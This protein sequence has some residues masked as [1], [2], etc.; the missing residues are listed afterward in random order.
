[1]VSERSEFHFMISTISPSAPEPGRFWLLLWFG[2]FFAT[3]EEMN[4]KPPL[5]I[6]GEEGVWGKK[7]QP[8]ISN[9]YL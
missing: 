1:M 6:L 3:E 4:E 5:P 8:L 2:F 9:I 7:G